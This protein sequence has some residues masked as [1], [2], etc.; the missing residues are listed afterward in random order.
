MDPNS[1]ASRVRDLQV[2]DAEFRRRM[3][4]L[5]PAG[6][7]YVI[8]FSPHAGSTWLKQVLSASGSLGFPDEYLNPGQIRS[9]AG[10][11]QTRDPAGLLQMLKRRRKTPNGVFGMEVR[12]IDVRFFGQEVFFSEFDG[13]TAFFHLWR[14]NIVAQA[15]SLYRAVATGTLHAKA[16]APPAPE[17]GYDAVKIESWLRQ[18][19]QIEN[20]NLDMLRQS[21]RAVQHLRYEDIVL[22]PDGTIERFARALGLPAGPGGLPAA[23][24][25]AVGN[26][27]DDWIT[28]AEQRFRAER[29][30]VVDKIETARLIRS[31]DTVP[32]LPGRSAGPHGLDMAS[33]MKARWHYGHRGKA[34]ETFALRLLQGG[35]I[36]G[37]DHP[38]ERVWRLQDGVLSFWRDDGTPVVRFD[39]VSGN[40]G[41]LVLEGKYLGD[42]NVEIVLRLEQAPPGPAPAKL[43][44]TVLA[45]LRA[46]DM[47]IAPPD[48]RQGE[49][50]SGEIRDVMEQSWARRRLTGQTVRITEWRDVFVAKE[51]LVFTRDMQLV[52]ASITQHSESDIAG[53]R[54]AIGQA[55]QEANLPRVSGTAVLCKKRGVGNYGH[56]L[57]EML[58]KA[59]LAKLLLNEPQLRVIIADQPGQ[60]GLVM[61]A[62]LA[63]VGLGAA[64]CVALGDAPALVDRLLLVDGL[65]QH[66]SYMSP[67]AVNAVSLLGGLAAPGPDRKVYVSRGS[68]HRRF[69]DEAAVAARAARAGYLVFDPGKAS[70]FDQIGAFS[71]AEVIVGVMGAGL[72][73]IVFAPP[74]AQVVSL[75]PANMPDTFFWYIAS[76][77]GLRYREVR[78]EVAGPPTGNAEWDC[79]L[80]FPEALAADI[81]P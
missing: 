25:Q 14:G 8:F 47:D 48:L 6:R 33:L 58:P 16:E 24:G 45:E 4:R 74:G 67:L 80:A 3:E 36:G 18:I 39:S 1:F 28:G 20:D 63:H 66:G 70:Q 35:A 31:L 50:L 53:A 19:V 44:E 9:L 71:G 65:T 59:I 11:M 10:A 13:K 46:P 72:T 40:P 69:R 30:D 7:C 52:P 17:P 56:W 26:I 37:Y 2:D 29:P 60:L 12:S 77:R 23:P 38:N 21:G 61:R 51:G 41:A 49:L 27:G 62:G 54:R 42:P 34:P 64:Q 68:T 22:D 75:A 43:V 76:L 73:N 15:V 79:D 55:V 57:I 78:C 81:F 5:T 32:P